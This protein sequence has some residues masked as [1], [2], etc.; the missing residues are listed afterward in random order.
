MLEERARFFL[1]LESFV[2]SSEEIMAEEG[3]TLTCFS[4]LSQ[5][6]GDSSATAGS[7]SSESSFSSSLTL[8]ITVI[9]AMLSC[10][11]RRAPEEETILEVGVLGVVGSEGQEGEDE[12]KSRRDFVI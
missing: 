8:Y 3:E 12:I 6:P 10:F 9:S 1:W 11:M 4:S 7:T 2:L 5:K